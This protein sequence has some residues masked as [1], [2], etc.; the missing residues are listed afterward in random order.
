MNA[1]IN[2]NK[3]SILVAASKN[4]F[5]HKKDILRTARNITIDPSEMILYDFDSLVASYQLARVGDSYVVTETGR[6]TIAEYKNFI[7][8]LNKEIQ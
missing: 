3:I 7:Q 8:A 2:Q 1:H 5:T 6:K 4:T